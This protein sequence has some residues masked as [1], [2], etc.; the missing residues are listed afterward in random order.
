MEDRVLMGLRLR[1]GIS[2]VNLERK[3]GVGLSSD[4]LD[5]L[6]DKNF[7]QMSDNRLRL[8]GKGFLLSNEIILKVLDSLIP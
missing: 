7:I 4:K 1:E 2:L 3:F 5:Y 8:T 6:M